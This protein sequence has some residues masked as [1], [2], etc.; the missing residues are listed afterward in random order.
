[1][2]LEKLVLNQIKKLGPTKAAAYFGVSV[3]TIY[4]WQKKHNPPISAAQ[5][6]LNEA[7]DKAQPLPGQ[8]VIGASELHVSDDVIAR[9]EKLER[10]VFD[11]ERKIPLTSGV[12]PFRHTESSVPRSAEITAKD[13][14]AQPIKG[15][16]KRTIRKKDWN[17]PA[18]ESVGTGGGGW[19]EPAGKQVPRNRPTTWN[20]PIERGDD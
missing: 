2:N 3:P 17:S 18:V 9:L 15:Q 13:G 12:I 7:K 20:Q 14:G 10:A 11:P 19:N 1:M 8:P 6:V 4:S 5:K 16:P